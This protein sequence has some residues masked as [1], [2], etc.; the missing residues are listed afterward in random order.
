MR[1]GSSSTLA[2]TTCMCI[3]WGR[4]KKAS[5]VLPTR[6]LTCYSFRGRRE[7]SRASQSLERQRSS[8]LPGYPGTWVSRAE[9]RRPLF[10]RVEIRTDEFY[11]AVDVEGLREKAVA[12]VI[13]WLPEGA[14]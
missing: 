3:T 9:R 10:V 13:S 1:F 14:H 11:Q 12:R 2:S 7:S 6:S 5:S 4:T 8:P